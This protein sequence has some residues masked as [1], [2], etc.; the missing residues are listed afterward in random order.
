MARGLA[1]I[2]LLCLAAALPA[3]QIEGVRLWTAP[4]HTR[5]VFDTSTAADHRV[6]TL[7]NPD[8]LVIDFAGTRVAAGF[9]D[10]D[11]ANKHLNGMRHAARR[12]GSLRVVLDLKQA[13]RP[14]TF[15]LQPN[16]GYGH[17]VVVDLYP[18]EPGTAKRV[19]R[20]TRDLARPRD[21]IIAVDA[22]HGGED[23]G[24]IGSRYRTHEKQVTL[25]IARRLKRVIDAQPGMRAVLTRSGDYYVGLRKRMA[26]ARRHSADLFVSIHADAFRDKRVRGSSVYVLS[27]RGASSEAARWLAAKENAADL[28][29][30]VSL[31]DKDDVLASVL[32]DLSQSATQHASLSAAAEV[33][34]QLRRVGDVHGKRVQQAGFMVLKSPDIP[35][36]LVETGFISN[37]TEERKLRDP[38]HQQRVAKAIMQGI[39]RYFAESP[40]PGT[41][42]AERENGGV[43]H[44]IVRGDTL[45]EIADRYQVSLA[46]LRSENRIR[47]DDHIRIGQVLVIPGT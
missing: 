14:K 2:L 22:G 10:P 18:A 11:V 19:A 16:A 8:R 33:Y 17:R 23:P 13:V 21:V 26:L 40:P 41:L 47:R 25:E 46:R 6:F 31:D 24:A 35:S 28:V 42:L 20:S 9:R 45:S 43:K 38:A 32:L 29:G 37:P 44:V 15:A 36:M 39:R 4:D 34:G 27:R 3:A 30:G 7:Q 12:D 5:L 1:T